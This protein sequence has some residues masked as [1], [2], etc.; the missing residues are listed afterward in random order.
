MITAWMVAVAALAGAPAADAPCVLVFEDDVPF[1]CIE[2]ARGWPLDRFAQNEPVVPESP[3]GELSWSTLPRPAPLGPVGTIDGHRLYGINYAYGL[4][5]LIGERSKDAFSPLLFIDPGDHVAAF[6]PPLVFS[7]QG[8]SLLA[9]RL[10]DSGMGALQQTLFLALVD[11]RFT[12]LES[13]LKDLFVYAK[14]HGITI[15]HRGG[16]FCGGTLIWQNWAWVGDKPPDNFRHAL[17][18]I[19]GV[20]DNRLVLQGVSLVDRTVRTEDCLGVFSH[21]E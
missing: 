13:E 20:Q 7:W 9:V 19:F 12:W 5:V 6:D 16:G 2:V 8:R 15:H 18:G 10:H 3:D 4:Y 14:M 11:G 17:R 1:E 21:G